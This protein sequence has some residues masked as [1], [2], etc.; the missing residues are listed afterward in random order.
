MPAGVV[1]DEN[2]RVF[3]LDT[4]PADTSAPT[5][6]EVNAGHDLTGYLAPDGLALNTGNSRVSGAD[7]LD[8]F[9]SESM[10]RHQAAPAL[11]FK[12]RLRGSN[13]Q[14]AWTTLG[15]RG[16]QGCLV[17]LPFLAPDDTPAAADDCYVFP[18]CET[19]VPQLANTAMNTEQRFI[20]PLAVGAAPVYDAVVA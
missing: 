2:T 11:T 17:V 6:A 5:A 4:N 10:G 1:F 7:L 18:F 16:V 3:W 12:R 20:T 13:A 8:G 9:D 19:G 14:V 15:A